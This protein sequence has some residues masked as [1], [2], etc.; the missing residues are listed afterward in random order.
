LTALAGCSHSYWQ[1]AYHA[2]AAC[3]SAPHPLIAASRLPF[4]QVVPKTLHLENTAALQLLA[5]WMGEE[6]AARAAEEMSSGMLVAVAL[7]HEAALGR[8]SRWAPYLATLPARPP[9]PWLLQGGELEA[10]AAAALAGRPN[11]SSSSGSS[12]SS[13]STNSSS[14]SSTGSVSEWVKAAEAYRLEVEGEVARACELLSEAAGRAEAARVNGPSWLAPEPLAWALAQVES[15]SLG[16]AGSSGLGES[17]GCL[18]VVGCCW[19]S[20]AVFYAR[21]SMLIPTND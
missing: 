19:Q 17:P 4:H 8:A 7:A 2:R 12:S 3:P 1:L 13:S 11:S 9:S 6:A 16:T 14:R 10:A 5:T 18:G 21:Q 15:R 20:P